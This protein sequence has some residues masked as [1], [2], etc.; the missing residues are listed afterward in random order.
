M[1][2]HLHLEPPT[3]TK[4]GLERISNLEKDDKPVARPPM[5]EEVTE[6]KSDKVATALIEIAKSLKLVALSNI[7]ASEEERMSLKS[8]L[9][10]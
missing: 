4:T 1:S 5:T 9:W 2:G 7:A 8:R 10:E 6:S 3:Q